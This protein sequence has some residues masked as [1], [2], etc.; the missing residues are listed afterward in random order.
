MAEV[1]QGDVID[2][3]D[4][5][6]RAYNALCSAEGHLLADDGPANHLLDEIGGLRERLGVIA[7]PGAGE[8]TE[9]S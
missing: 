2:M 3:N 1:P 7:F 5:L 8:T 9:V 6:Q 4:R